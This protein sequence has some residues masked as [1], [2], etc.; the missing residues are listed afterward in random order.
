MGEWMHW[1]GGSAVRELG[2]LHSEGQTQ[3]HPHSCPRPQWALT[4]S[5]HLAFFLLTIS[6]L[7]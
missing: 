3:A 1:G 2:N 5:L 4:A 7:I 6:G